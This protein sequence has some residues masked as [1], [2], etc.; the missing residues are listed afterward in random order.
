MNFFMI[1]HF[2]PI[3]RRPADPDEEKPGEPGVRSEDSEGDGDD[4]GHLSYVLMC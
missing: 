1:D 2:I 4:E 3:M